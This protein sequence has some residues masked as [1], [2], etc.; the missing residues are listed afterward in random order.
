VWGII[1]LEYFY[2]WDP[3]VPKQIADGTR[4]GLKYLLENGGP[5]EVG[6]KHKRW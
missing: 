3:E 6:R 2:E 4:D 5:E 1:G